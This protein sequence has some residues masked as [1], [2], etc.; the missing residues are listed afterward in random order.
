LSGDDVGG[1]GG[2]MVLRLWKLLG[3]MNDEILIGV[4][5]YLRMKNEEK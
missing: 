3:R 4:F 5:K 2:G 1:R